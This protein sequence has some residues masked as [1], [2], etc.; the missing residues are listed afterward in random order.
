M[1]A[2][3]PSLA[4]QKRRDYKICEDEAKYTFNIINRYVFD[5]QL[6]T[7]NF[8][9]KQ[10]RHH[11]G[12]CIGD[13]KLANN[14]SYCTIELNRKFYCVQWFV[15]ILAHEMSH[16]YQWEVLSIER[17]KYGLEPLLSHGPSFF[18]YRHRLAEYGIPLK[19]EYSTGR[20]VKYQDLFKT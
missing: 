2:V 11:W 3:L 1:Q 7:P 16:Q 5:D 9:I 18:Q 14:Q 8:I 13:I 6:P 20:W 10:S 4:S 12:Q 19:T 17:E 15:T